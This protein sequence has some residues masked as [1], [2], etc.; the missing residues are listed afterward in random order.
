MKKIIATM[1]ALVFSF[2]FAASVQAE[3]VAG[4]TFTE[5][6]LLGLKAELLPDDLREGLQLEAGPTYYLFTLGL[7]S[8]DEGVNSIDLSLPL[9][10]GS[11][12]VPEPYENTIINGSYFP[13]VVEKNF[14]PENGF[15]L[16][17]GTTDQPANTT[18]EVNEVFGFV[19]QVKASNT[20]ESI[21]IELKGAEE[22]QVA[23]A[24]LGGDTQ[25]TNL[26]TDILSY[27]LSGLPVSEVVEEVVTE[28]EV[29]ETPIVDEAPDMVQE[30][31]E[32][33]A[34][35]VEEIETGASPTA[36]LLLLSLLASGSFLIFNRQ[37]KA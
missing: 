36:V 4:Y 20:Q 30:V 23:D 2:L 11:L 35:P 7:R 16:Y 8:N 29:V 33:I 15:I 17:Q 22:G 3:D 37:K 5:G 13:N 19:A 32:P 21:T 27:T 1:L 24:T 25:G 6:G 14:N 31:D 28:P 10:T 12:V 9:P 26:Y 34:I 18:S